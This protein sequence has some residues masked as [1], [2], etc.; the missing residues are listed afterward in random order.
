MNWVEFQRREQ[1]DKRWTKL[2]V[3]KR[4]NARDRCRLT[5]VTTA[6]L[7]RLN[8]TIAVVVGRTDGLSVPRRAPSPLFSSQIDVDGAA[9]S[10]IIW[11]AAP[12]SC[13][14]ESRR[15][16]A[17]AQDH[18]VVWH[19]GESQTS[20]QTL[21]TGIWGFD[22]ISTFLTNT[23][24]S[25]Y[26]Y[27]S[28]ATFLTSRRGESSYMTSMYILRTD[29]STTDYRPRILENFEWPYLGNGSPVSLHVWF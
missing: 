18:T 1:T 21:Y 19:F 25:A 13:I 29:R 17:T 3:T 5:A 20:A 10:R 6:A 27:S 12:T 28:R 8:R 9:N 14:P 16:L 11:T 15:Q 26:F 24:S 22:R 2:D 23:V 7:L 4:R